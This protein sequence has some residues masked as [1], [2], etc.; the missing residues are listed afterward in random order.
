MGE[1]CCH[2]NLSTAR[3]IFEAG[4]WGIGRKKVYI[5]CSSN[6][7]KQHAVKEIKRTIIEYQ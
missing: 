2:F 5:M 3:N 7:K 1:V 6:L 4:K